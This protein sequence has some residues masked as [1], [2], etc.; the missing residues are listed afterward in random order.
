MNRTDDGLTI[1]PRHV[2]VA[3]ARNELLAFLIDWRKRNGLT[4][5][6]WLLLAS[7]AVRDEA[8]LLVRHERKRQ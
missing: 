3:T 7:E 6:E 8:A 2:P 1:S 4:E 5:A